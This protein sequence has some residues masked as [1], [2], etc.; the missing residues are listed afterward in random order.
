MTARDYIDEIKLR[1]NRLGVSSTLNDPLIL[2]YVNKA[3]RDVQVA[4]M[5]VVPEKYGR[6]DVVN[7]STAVIDDDAMQHLYYNIP[8]EVR[9]FPLPVDYLDI[10]SF[11]LSW[12]GNFREARKVNKQ[13]LHNVKT[14]CFN[15][16]T[17]D[18]PI[19]ILESKQSDYFGSLD[20]I[21][22]IAGVELNGQS[23]FETSVVTA[24]IWAIVTLQDF[25]RYN[26]VEPVFGPDLEEF[27]VKQAMIYC[28]NDIKHIALKQSLQVQANDY[29]EMVL[30]NYTVY[31]DKPI[32]K[33]P[34]QEGI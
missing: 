13:E 31:R 3:R 29:K 6:R 14:H 28:M 4:T 19:Y 1:L 32:L 10:V 2:N 11:W 34:S 26:E 16:P 27:T 8:I 5:G 7:I 22:Y 30:Q 17:I 9:R 25:D 23:I 12:D 21:C 20:N 24:E 15:A 33:L 18:R